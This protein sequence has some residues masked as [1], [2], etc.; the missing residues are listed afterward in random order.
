MIFPIVEEAPLGKQGRT[1]A[2]PSAGAMVMRGGGVWRRGS[3]ATLWNTIWNFLLTECSTLKSSCITAKECLEGKR[4]EPT[5]RRGGGG[6]EQ[7]LEGT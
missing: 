7:C 6:A 5:K 3:R 4:D 1:S 2:A